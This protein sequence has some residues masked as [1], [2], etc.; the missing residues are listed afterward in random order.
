MN[1]LSFKEYYE[2]KD[3]L[4]QASK[5]V[6]RVI[7]EYIVKKYCKVPIVAEST[8]E[9]ISLK[10]KDVIKILWEFHDLNSLPLAKTVY[11]GDAKHTPAWSSD[12][13]KRWAMSHALEKAG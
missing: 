5:D 9:Y 12:K 2:S 4:L 3:R 1:K 13:L 8:K 10:P 7:T 6:P 11:F